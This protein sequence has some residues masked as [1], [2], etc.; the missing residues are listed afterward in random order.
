M[1]TKYINVL[2][3][4]NVIYCIVLYSIYLFNTRFTFK[5]FRITK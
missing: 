5:S 1:E 2:T 4:G 3:Y